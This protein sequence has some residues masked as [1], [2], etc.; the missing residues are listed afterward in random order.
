MNFFEKGVERPF[1]KKFI[2]RFSNARK[3][4][5]VAYLRDEMAFKTVGNSF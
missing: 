1:Q 3:I 2:P 4:S 5:G